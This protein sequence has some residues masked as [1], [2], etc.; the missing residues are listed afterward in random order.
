MSVG[1]FILGVALA[2][3]IVVALGRFA[4]V[5]RGRLLPGWNGAPALLAAVALGLAAFL[6]IEILLGLVGLLHAPALVLACVGLGAGAELAERRGWGVPASRG[7]EPELP[8]PPSR[9]RWGMAIALAASVWIVG[10]WFA[11]SLTDLR[12][13]PNGGDSIWYHLPFAARFAEEAA[14]TGLHYTSPTFLSW[15]YPANSELLNSGWI[16]LSGGDSALPAVN[17]LWLGLA[18]L[19]AW[20]VGRPYGVAPLTLVATALL[21]DATA[22]T[23]TQPGSADNDIASVALILTAA[24]LIVNR[25]AVLRGS[26]FEVGPGLATVVAAVAGIAIGNK[27]MMVVPMVVLVVG[28]VA[29]AGRGSHLR[30]GIAAAVAA[31][32][33]GGFWFARNL[34]ESGNPVPWRELS[35]G[36]I[37]LPSPDETLGGGLS[38]SVASYWNDPWVWIDWF[39]PGLDERF[40]PLWPL[41]IG[42]AVAGVIIALL[43]GPDRPRRLLGA[44]GCVAFLTY[45]VMPLTAEGPPGMPVNF[46]GNL[47]Q[48]A[49]AIALGLALLPIAWR[50]PTWTVDRV[51]PLAAGGLAVLVVTDAPV[52]A[53]EGGVLEV[54][55]VGSALAALAWAL[56]L[57]LERVS[58]A[59][60]R[61]AMV[62]LIVGAVAVGGG[63]AVADSDKRY[64][65]EFSKR[66]VATGMDEVFRWAQE[67]EGARIGTTS[68]LQY[69]LY[70]PELDNYVE[71]V[72]APGPDGAFTELESCEAWRERI[73]ERDYDYLVVAPVYTEDAAAVPLDWTRGP[74]TERILSRRAS[75]VF[76]VD[77]PLDPAEC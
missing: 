30:T 76:A 75:S 74:A 8:A 16:V 40:G 13:G 38:S 73:N 77:G 20:C 41:V 47:R 52:G 22:L 35:L 59:R 48:A 61:A 9:S 3:V 54:L 32:A 37:S 46:D 17:L 63:I 21:L 18:L 65:D 33:T 50:L 66:M 67:V 70:G 27:L 64:Q 57:G 34:L 7:P 71:Y 26:R 56:R 29:L 36:P 62:A 15:F 1:G 12:Y 72:G 4:V 39:V 11:L 44:V 28:L 68:I 19:A 53:G 10:D 58:P 43:G 45:L 24:A 31:A 60:A 42:G 69:G 14:I 25:A 2:G 23:A 5:A 49:A 51:A 6:V 55:A